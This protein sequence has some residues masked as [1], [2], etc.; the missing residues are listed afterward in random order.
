MIHYSIDYI[1]FSSPN[2]I[3]ID[4]YGNRK[5][6]WQVVNQS[7]APVRFYRIGYEFSN[8]VRA[9]HGNTNSD[10]WLYI[11]SG[12]TCENLGVDAS[13]IQNIFD[14]H[15]KISRI[16]F[17][18]TTDNNFLRHMIRDARKIESRIYSKL[19]F[20]GDSS[21]EPQTVY[22]GDMKKR[23]RKGIVRAYNKSL[24]LGLDES[25]TKLYRFEYESRKKKA[26]ID[27]KRYARGVS[28]PAIILS[29]I[30]IDSDWF[31][32]LMSGETEPAESRIY[33]DKPLETQIARKMRW[34]DKQVVPTL[35][36]IIDYDRKYGTQ[37][38]TYLMKLLGK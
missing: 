5:A 33:D 30:N 1:Q 18:I 12:K 26:Q 23:G 20:I 17:A 31:K 9:Y 8:G 6:A 29:R 4:R 27:A 32:Y 35:R 38:W 14:N 34:V 11:L 21:I 25:E 2:M 36:Y 16:D 3:W 24:E 28:I 22:L 15:G 13:F 37:N 7:I 10:N 19:L